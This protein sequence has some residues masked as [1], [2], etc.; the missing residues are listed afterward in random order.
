MKKWVIVTL[1][2]GNEFEEGF[3]D[4]K[5]EAIEDA[6]SSYHDLSDFDKK[7]LDDYYVGLFECEQINGRWFTNEDNSEAEEIALSFDT[8]KNGRGI[9]YYDWKFYELDDAKEYF[10]REYMEDFDKEDI[11]NFNEELDNVNSFMELVD[12]LESWK[13]TF[14]D[15][16]VFEVLYV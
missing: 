15:K 7:D 13:K 9:E 6:I 11:D 5:D 16:R 12:C 8:L 3:F 10:R 4:N 1:K 2:N 14:E